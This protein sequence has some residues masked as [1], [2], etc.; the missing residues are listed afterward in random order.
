MIALREITD[1]LPAYNHTY[2][3]DGSDAVAYIKGG[4]TDPIYF[5]KPLKID[6]RGRKFI[7]L[8]VNPFAAVKSDARLWRVK[9]KSNVYLVTFKNDN[10]NCQCAGFQFRGSCKH[11]NGVMDKYVV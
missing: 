9:S 11:I 2:L 7:E 6:R 3:F 5:K 8:K 10:W 1:W 4:S